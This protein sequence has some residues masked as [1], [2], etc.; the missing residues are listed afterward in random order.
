MAA[1]DPVGA[2]SDS[3]AFPRLA[4]LTASFP[5]ATGPERGR[6]AGRRTGVMVAQTSTTRAGAA[7]LRSGPSTAR[8]SGPNPRSNMVSASS[9]TTCGPGI[10]L[11]LGARARLILKGR[12]LADA[13]ASC[14]ADAKARRSAPR[15]SPGTGTA[16]VMQRDLCQDPGRPRAAART[17]HAR[18]PSCARLRT[19]AR[20]RARP[21]AAQHSRAAPTDERMP[22][23]LHEL[24]AAGPQHA[25][26][27]MRAPHQLHVAIEQVAAA[28]VLRHLARRAHQD[29][30]RRG[31][32]VRL[33]RKRAACA[34]ARRRIALT[35]AARATGR[36]C[37][38][39]C[40]DHN[41]RQARAVS[42]VV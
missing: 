38:R 41:P 33:L 29:V 31:Q 12:G 9:S 30:Q 6:A 35:L 18:Q 22:P 7:L 5:Q 25:G 42:A 34:R 36:P 21:L 1:G 15:S 39:G 32:R 14:T 17:C 10:G 2:T 37:A 16:R 40:N 13:S 19:A 24:R 26:A 4:S 11:W 20:R 27:G 28:G 8:T 3:S 23:R